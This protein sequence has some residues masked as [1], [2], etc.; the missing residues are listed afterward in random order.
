MTATIPLSIRTPTLLALLAQIDTS[1]GPWG[2]WPWRGALDEDGYGHFGKATRLA[3]RAVYEELVGPIPDGHSIDH[4]CHNRDATCPGGRDCTHRR[5]VNP[6][7][8][9][10]VTQ[11]ENVLRS[12]RTMPHV[13]AAKTHCPAGHEYTSDNTY[14]Y[15]DGRRDCRACRTERQRSQ[16]AEARRRRAA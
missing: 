7:H 15:R 6:S 12:T 9:E 3:H 16:R 10:P 11:G 2:C 13:N 8:L 1:A 14:R 4:G 5:C